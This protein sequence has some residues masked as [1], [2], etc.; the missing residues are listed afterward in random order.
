VLKPDI[1]SPFLL[2]V[3][4]NSPIVKKQIRAKQFTQNIIDSLGNRAMELIVPIPKDM[5]LRESLA[6]EAQKIVEKRA[7]LR[8]KGRR[9]SVQLTESPE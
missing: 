7:E 1:I 8:E 4:L 3:A 6:S 5:K 9:L 2:L